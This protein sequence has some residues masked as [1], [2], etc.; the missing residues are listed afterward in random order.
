MPPRIPAVIENIRFARE[1]TLRLLHAVP[2]AEWF[3]MPPAGVSHIGWQVGHIAMAQF[4]LVLERVRGPR[5]DDTELLPPLFLELFGRGSIPDPNVAY[6]SVEVIRAVFDRVHSR[7][8]ADL[9]TIPDGQLDLKPLTPHPLCQ[10]RLQCLNWCSH[11][12][13]LHAGQIGLIRRQ[14]GHPMLW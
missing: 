7:V 14:L 12:E 13:A 8:L 11:H 10:T 9:P 5:P 2:A 4:R 1:Y 3:V 6:P